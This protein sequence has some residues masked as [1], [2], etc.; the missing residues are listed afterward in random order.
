MSDIKSE[1]CSKVNCGSFSHKYEHN[2]SRYNQI[3]EELSFAYLRQI[4][5]YI[6]AGIEYAGKQMDNSGVDV[7]ISLPRGEGH[8][9]PLHLDVQLKGTST[10]K[11]D[12]EGHLAYKI[13]KKLFDDL[14]S[15]KKCSPWLL[16]VLI[17][18]QDVEGW[19]SIEEKELIAR[20]SMLWYDATGQV[21]KP[22]K[23]NITV[24]IPLSN[25][26]DENSLYHLLIKQMEVNE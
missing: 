17:L 6:G 13:D 21:T 10:P 5:A 25:K 9:I 8:P 23:K 4:C 24:K 11:Y 1:K 12:R 15:K 14:S 7:I 2:N 16:F 18:P 19:I 3:K 22:N 20:G 26:V